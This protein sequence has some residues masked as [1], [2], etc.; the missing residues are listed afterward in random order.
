MSSA[1]ERFDRQLVELRKLKFDK[2]ECPA[3]RGLLET[4][5]PL[6]LMTCPVCRAGKLARRRVDEKWCPVC[7]SGALKTLRNSSSIRICPIC[8]MGRLRASGLLRRR[9]ECSECHASFAKR[10]NVLTLLGSGRNSRKGVEEGSAGDSDAYWLPLSGRSRIVVHCETCKAHWDEHEDGSM[11]L[12]RWEEDPF[13]VARKH[14]ALTKAEWAKVG[15]RLRPDSG[16]MTCSKCDA[17]FLADGEEIVPLHADHDPYGFIADYKGCRLTPDSLRF[18]G[19]YKTSGNPGPVCGD[20][21]TEFD[22]EGDYLRLRATVNPALA[23]YV[24]QARPF[25]DWHRLARGLPAIDEEAAWRDAYEGALRRA[26]VTGEVRW[27]DK[28][29]ADLLW[30]SDAELIE[31]Q[32]RGRMLLYRESIEFQ[33]KRNG[34]AA[35]RDVVR[36]VTAQ[37]DVVT[38]DVVGRPEPLDFRIRPETVSIELASGKREVLLDAEDFAEA[39]RHYPAAC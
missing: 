32:A 3:C 24:D 18:L 15:V 6:R 36:G 10:A 37:D 29:K 2:R 13:G 28:K 1:L 21:R 14:R 8:G 7:R 39:I 38:L 25:E 31:P 17:D 34:W 16:N 30:R 19:V 20:C 27:A 11:S 26:L 33:S 35:P 23:A 12:F 5:T 22:A 4:A 9:L